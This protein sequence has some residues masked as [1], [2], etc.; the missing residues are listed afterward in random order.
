MFTVSI[1][2]RYNV[3]KTILFNKLQ[4]KK[5]GISY[6]FRGLTRDRNEAI[7]EIK[8]YKIKIIDTPG[9]SIEN[10]VISQK[11]TE[12][13]IV[14][15]RSSNL[16]FFVLDISK[17]L[18][19]DDI[20]IIKILQKEKDI[21]VCCMLNKSDIKNSLIENSREFEQIKKYDCIS[22]S[23]EHNINLHKV[24][25]I[26]IDRIEKSS[27]INQ[28]EDLKEIIKI[29]IVGRPNAGKSTFINRILKEERLLTDSIAGT[30]RDAISSFFDYK[31]YKI[32]IIDTA[33]IRRKTNIIRDSIEE[34]SVKEAMKS[35]DFA[36]VCILMMDAENSFEDQDFKIAKKIIE[37]GRILILVLNK[38][39]T[40]ERNYQNKFIENI[41]KL[42]IKKMPEVRNPVFF[43][44][45]AIKDSNFNEFFD[46]IIKLY[47]DWN[48]RFTKKQ[49]KDITEEINN[50]SKSVEG[51]ILKVRSIT[52]I[53]TR[54]PCFLICSN[55]DK[56]SAPF[57][58]LSFLRNKIIKNLNIE[59]ISIKLKFE[60]Y[61]K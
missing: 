56:N 25:D 11:M 33:G 40:V 46:E 44:L 35:I 38:W 30:T 14:A 31:N 39:D 16:V 36:N 52:Q 4:K 49:L 2:G 60:N 21:N 59:G 15:L 22:I 47:K 45:S 8:N 23:A 12:Q 58:L 43:T 29:S 55:F 28:Q 48:Q 57:H 61:H 19:N 32:E 50:L 53:K 5:V 41:T 9:I 26:I 6:D 37:E 51:K 34:M 27:F 13:S 24:R 54:P 7:I 20:E 10:S 1:I 17:N 18:E 42:L 3:G